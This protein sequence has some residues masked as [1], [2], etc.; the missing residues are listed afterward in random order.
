MEAIMVLSGGF[1]FADLSGGPRRGR[2]RRHRKPGRGRYRQRR[3]CD[4]PD[5]SAKNET[6]RQPHDSSH[7][8]F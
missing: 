3:E 5:S 6:S 8:L 4:P 2:V 7:L 1:V